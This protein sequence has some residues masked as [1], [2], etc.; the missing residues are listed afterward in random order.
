MVG[1]VF[2]FEEAKQEFDYIIDKYEDFGERE[3]L[4]IQAQ[5]RLHRSDT[6]TLLKGGKDWLIEPLRD[7]QP[8]SFAVLQEHASNYMV[9]FRWER[10]SPRPD[11]PKDQ[12]FH[13]GF[14]VV[15]GRVIWARYGYESHSN[16]YIA[17]VIKKSWLA[18]SRGWGT[19]EMIV[20]VNQRQFICD[21]FS[22][23]TPFSHVVA[24]IDKNWEK[25]L[26]PSLREKIPN[27]YVTRTNP[28]DGEEYEWVSFR[29]FLDSRLPED[30]SFIGDQLYVVDSNPDGR[31]YWI[32]DFDFKTVYYLNNPGEAI[33]A[34][35]AHTLLQT[36]GRFDFSP[37]AVKL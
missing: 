11:L 31:I 36:P 16:P 28:H 2:T 15:K 25:T 13:D 24:L 8:L 34:Y 12:L 22:E 19:T 9:G 26:L 21:S 10:E 18:R 30:Y 32:K 29:C 23:W 4:Y 37:W 35:S 27:L 33:D 5:N 6:N 17:E 1:H 3:S 7:L 20:P 14:F